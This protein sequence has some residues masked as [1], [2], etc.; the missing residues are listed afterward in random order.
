MIIDKIGNASRY[1]PLGAGIAE[2]FE[3]I[4][5]NDL[6]SIE[7][8]KYDLIEG[9]LKMI[10]NE[11]EQKCI[12]RVKMEVHHENIDLQYWV[13]G[14]ELM[15]YAPLENQSPMEPFNKEKDCGFY[16]GNGDFTK[17]KPGMFAIYFPYELH[18]AVVDSEGDS[19][20]RKIVYKIHVE[21]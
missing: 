19:N 17:L 3:H 21:K 12:D 8:G 1:Y 18:T 15:G 2:A 11:Y 13:S 10:V 20:V 16:A 4:S 6:K 7:K 14:T 9:K 5:H